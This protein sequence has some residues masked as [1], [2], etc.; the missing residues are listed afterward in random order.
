MT[1]VVL[2]VQFCDQHI[3]FFRASSL[4]FAFWFVVFVRFLTPQDPHSHP[5]CSQT[6]VGGTQGENVCYWLTSLLSGL[7]LVKFLALI[8]VLEPVEELE[9][10]VQCGMRA[11]DCMRR[12]FGRRGPCL[13]PQ[14]CVGWARGDTGPDALGLRCPMVAP[15]HCA[16]R[17]LEM[18]SSGMKDCPRKVDSKVW[19]LDDIKYRSDFW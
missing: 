14:H 13:P 18:S 8:S 11:L 15:G 2:S 1:A 3:L 5:Q 6:C 10:I 9:P 7:F 19:R 12:G 17:A 16:C 4:R